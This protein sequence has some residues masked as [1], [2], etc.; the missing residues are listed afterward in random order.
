MDQLSE[1]LSGP[2]LSVNNL[3]REEHV[4]GIFFQYAYNLPDKLTLLGGL[5]ADHSSIY[6]TFYTPRLHLKYNLSDATT[7]RASAGKG[8]RTPN[9]IAENNSFLTTS[10]QIFVADNPDQEEAWNYGTNV[11]HYFHPGQKEVALT[12]EYYRTDFNHQLIVDLDQSAREVHFYNLV[13]KSRSNTFQASLSSEI[14]KGLDVL[15][16]WRLNDVKVTTNE[17][18][19]EKALQSRHKGLINLSYAPPLN[20]WQFDFT[21]QFNGPGRLPSTAG[22][23]E[24]LQRGD[25]FKGYEMI[26]AQITKNY[27][28]WNLYAGVENL[29]G[30]TQA[31]PIIDAQSPFSNYFD[32]SMVWGP[33]V[34]R[35]FYFGFRF[36]IDRS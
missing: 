19:Q 17:T 2:A 30:F 18:L 24:D 13:G 31:N 20:K 5:R 32:S 27:K 10:R 25:T 1:E 35:R 15:L 23:P 21:T 8:Y 16:A 22:N 6:G 36:S 3:G 7:L 33:I 9:A 12:L 14:L 28:T 26:N 11:A 29:T 4:P 34:G